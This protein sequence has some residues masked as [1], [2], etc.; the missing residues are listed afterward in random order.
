MKTAIERWEPRIDVIDV[1]V[2]FDSGQDG[3]VYVDLRYTVRGVNDPRN[4]VF[5]F[6]V[7]PD[8]PALPAPEDDA[9]PPS[10]SALSSSGPGR[11]EG[12]AAM[13]V[14]R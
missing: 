14:A 3:T 4:L 11:P 13:A 6:Y 10:R 5:P 7:I 2:G 9:V 1:Q 12:R 8:H